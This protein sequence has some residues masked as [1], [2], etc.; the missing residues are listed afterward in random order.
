VP[1]PAIAAC[2]SL[3]HNEAK[4]EQLMVGNK[5]E[6]W[7]ILETWSKELGIPVETIRQRL[8]GVVS[9]IGRHD[10]RL[11]DFYREE[12]V[13]QRCADLLSK[14]APSNP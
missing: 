5:T 3:Q 13:R 14:N 4:A 7:A 8:S 6:K 1:V 9:V 2:K 11:A 12:D 10:K